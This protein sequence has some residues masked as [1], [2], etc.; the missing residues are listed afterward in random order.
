M[1]NEIMNKLI[2]NE[3]TIDEIREMLSACPFCGD[4]PE[5]WKTDI[6]GFIGMR[7]DNPNCW[8]G[9]AEV[10][11]VPDQL[12]DVWNS[13][14]VNYVANVSVDTSSLVNDTIEYLKN[15]GYTITKED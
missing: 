6:K 13:R 8:A 7:C 11:G 14:V 10:L 12:I 9:A 2:D 4:N 1:K 5:V 3:I 15:N